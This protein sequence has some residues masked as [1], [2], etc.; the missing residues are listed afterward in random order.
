MHDQIPDASL[1]ILPDCGHLSTLE[2]AEQVNAI[3]AEWLSR[4]L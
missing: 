1:D 2:Q 3:L 4:P